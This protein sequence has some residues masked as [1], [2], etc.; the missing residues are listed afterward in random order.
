MVDFKKVIKEVTG[1]D[2]LSSFKLT[3]DAQTN[4]IEPVY[5]W[6]LDFVKDAGYDVEKVV[7]NFITTPGSGHFDEFG[8][9]K[10]TLQEKVSTYLGAINQVI[11]SIINLLYDLKEFEIRLKHY[12]KAKSNNKEEREAGMLALKQIWMDNVDIK[13]GRGSINQMTFELGF[14]TLRDAFMV[15]NSIE[16]VKKNEVLNDQIKRILIPRLSEFLEWK[17]LS[18]KELRNRFEIE[19]NYLRSQVETVKLYASWLSPYLKALQQLNQTGNEKDPSLVNA[20]STSIF[21]LT[22]L[23]KKKIKPESIFNFTK[24]FPRYIPSRDYFACVLISFNYRGHYSQR[25]SQKGDMAFGFGGRVD[26]T[27]ESYALNSDELDLIKKKFEDYKLSEGIRFFEENTKQSLENLKEDLEHFL[28]DNKKEKKEERK[29]EEDINPFSAL[30]SL[31]SN[32][33][34]SSKSEKK[35]IENS[36]DIR[37]DN[38]IEEII[39]ENAAQNAKSFLYSV[40]DVYKKAHAMPSPP[41]SFDY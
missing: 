30:F 36:E 14:T 38:H 20:F 22:I 2:P 31:F 24:N 29:S 27:F 4:Q 39:R 23:G 25:I 35:K 11:K 6:L 7:D 34:S 40:Y 37:K 33:F 12:E 13:K 8:R 19:K 41:E 17:N 32:L 15:C 18:E 9:K 5:Y 28:G 1:N 3:Y 26:I 21:E 16:D 10:G